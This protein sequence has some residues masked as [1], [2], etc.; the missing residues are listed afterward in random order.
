MHR[1]T[2]SI[3]DM[4]NAFQNTNDP[5]HEMGCFSSQHYYLD[6]FEKSYRNIP[7][8]QD[9][10]QFF[11]QYMH[12]TEITKPSG[13]KLNRLFDAVVT[14]SKYNKSTIDHDIYIKVFSDW[15][16]YYPMVST[17]DVLNTINN[18]KEFPELR[19]VLK[20]IL[21]LNTN[22]YMSLIRYISTFTSFLFFSVLI[23]LIISWN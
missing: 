19:I 13:W 10:G 23:R 12:V 2:S 8:N 17:D 11:L 14:I 1:L 18:E 3:L 6:W 20:N 22:N 4:S 15:P 9:G 7:F 16:L 21:I 5:I